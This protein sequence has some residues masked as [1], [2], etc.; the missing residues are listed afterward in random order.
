MIEY[1]ISI[2]HIAEKVDSTMESIDGMRLK[3]LQ[4]LKSVQQVKKKALERE[5]KRLSDKYGANHRRA[6][7]L[8]AKMKLNEGLMK[9]IDMEIDRAS[10]KYHPF[11]KL[12]WMVQGRVLNKNGKGIEGL[13]IALHDE[14]GQWIRDL[15]YSCTDNF[16]YFALIY[17]SK[18]GKKSEIKEDQE[19]FLT[20]SDKKQRILHKESDPLFVKIGKRDSRLIVITD[21]EEIC[22]PP[23][24]GKKREAG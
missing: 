7:K 8:D 22:T 10:I 14:E 5:K 11:D 12:T 24:A 2:E 23:G 17:P 3:N 18:K 4:N 16:G 15:G 9:G 1:K 21:L 6:K 20:V 13:T 19:L